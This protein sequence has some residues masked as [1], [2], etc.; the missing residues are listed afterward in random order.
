MMQWKICLAAVAVAQSAAGAASQASGS[1]AGW[2]YETAV[3]LGTGQPIVDTI[4]WTRMPVAA[5]L[6]IHAYLPTHFGLMIHNC[7]PRLWS[8]SQD[9]EIVGYSNADELLAVLREQAPAM[10]A[11][12]VEQCGTDPSLMPDFTDEEFF[13]KFYRRNAESHAR[14][15]D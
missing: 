7:S 6:T 5:H 1:P 14:V 8:F 13:R 4:R 2:E 10:V 15:R 3:D 12:A 9:F 11:R